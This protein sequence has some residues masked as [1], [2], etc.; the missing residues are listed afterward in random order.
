LPATVP[1][2]GVVTLDG[3]PVAQASVVFVADVGTYHATGVTDATGNFKLQAFPDRE[4]ALPG[5]YKVQV[6]KTVVD[7]SG[8]GVNVQF[9][10][11]EAYSTAATSGLISTIPQGGTT[12]LKIELTSAGPTAAP[13]VEPTAEPTAPEP[14]PAEPTPSDPEPGPAEPA[15]SP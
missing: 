7:R 10:L 15:S 14:T 13:P 11:P 5:W 2:S 4:G 12:T 1:A 6:S 3:V 8:G 9:G